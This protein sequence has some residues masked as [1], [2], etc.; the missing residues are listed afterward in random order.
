MPR[1]DDF[2][3]GRSPSFP[4]DTSAE[5][6]TD[7]SLT[8]S[9]PATGRVRGRV[10]NSLDGSPLDSATVKIRT[11]AGDPVAHTQTNPGGNYM[12]DSIAPGT[13]TINV[14]LHGF[15]TPAGQT[16]TLQGGQTL[17]IA[18]TMTPEARPLNVLYGVITNEA[19]GLPLFAVKVA[20]VPSTGGMANNLSW[21]N[22][23]GQYLMAEIED[24]DY[25]LAAHTA[26]F[27]LTSRIPITI[28]GGQILRTDL[29]MQPVA[30]PQGTVNGYIKQ[31]SG[32][33]IPNACVGLYSLDLSG[34]ETLQK[35]AFTDSNGFYIF[36]RVTAG[37]YLVKAKSEK[38]VTEI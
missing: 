12:F 10:T 4:L 32:T 21:T 27:Y 6:R 20:L 16:F 24:G 11:Q 13:Y 31:Q 18:F 26:G 30:V 25:F 22:S 9:A 37:T 1:V 15:V 5:N 2:L 28:S 14:A 34:L 29:A 36:G 19:T 33:P 38:V 7:L 17:D 23:S 3:L 35:V 8:Q